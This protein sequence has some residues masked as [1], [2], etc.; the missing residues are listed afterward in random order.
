MDPQREDL[1]RIS[2]DTIQQWQHIKSEYTNT[3]IGLLD[4]RLAAKGKVRQ[5]DKQLLVTHLH[6]V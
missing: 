3:S 1:P 2:V 5:Q 4:A 6:Q